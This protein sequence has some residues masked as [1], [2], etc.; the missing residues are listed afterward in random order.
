[1][2][3]GAA[4]VF[5]EAVQGAINFSR[6]KTGEEGVYFKERARLLIAIQSELQEDS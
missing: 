3:E 2:S 4:K 1:L 6:N 5:E